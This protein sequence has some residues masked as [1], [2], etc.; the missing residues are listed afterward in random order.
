MNDPNTLKNRKLLPS[1]GLKGQGE[2]GINRT[3][4]E[5][6]PKAAEVLVKNLATDN[7]QPSREERDEIN[8]QT[9]S[10]STCPCFTLLPIGKIQREARVY[11]STGEVMAQRKL[12]IGGKQTCWGRWK[13]AHWSLSGVTFTHCQMIQPQG[14]NQK[15]CFKSLYM[16][17]RWTPQ[18]KLERYCICQKLKT[19][20]PLSQTNSFS[21]GTSRVPGPNCWASVGTETFECLVISSQGKK[22]D[23]KARTS[24]S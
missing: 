11:G 9:I 18:V 16:W 10:S 3:L 14:P 19:K 21:V 4:V 1:L 20:S 23:T 8:T 2:R 24:Y 22:H 12:K 13:I 6:L 5:G 17:F 15:I 7:S